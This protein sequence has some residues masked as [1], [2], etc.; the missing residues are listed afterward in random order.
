MSICY[1]KGS[2][3]VLGVLEVGQHVKVITDNL[4]NAIDAFLENS[5]TDKILHNTFRVH[6]IYRML[7][8]HKNQDKVP[9]SSCVY[10]ALFKRISRT[11][12]LET[13]IIFIRLITYI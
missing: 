2:R 3:P 8:N 4:I 6:Y 9:W 5:Y 10:C 11:H 7:W 13:I 12:L 1:I